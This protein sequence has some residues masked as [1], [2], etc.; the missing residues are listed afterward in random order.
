VFTGLIEQVGLVQSVAPGPVTDVWIESTFEDLKLGESIACDGCCLT[1]VKAD[2][3]RFLVQA[4]PETLRRTTLGQWHTGTQL[5]LERAM[6][7]GDRLG[8]HIVQGHVD[9]TSRVLEAR[10]DGGSRFMRFDMPRELAAYF[11]EKGSVAIDGI[12]LTVNA[13]DAR[14]FAVQLIPETQ[15]RTTL[16]KKSTG[17]QVNL[18][19]DLVGKYVARQAQLLKEGA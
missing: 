8:G 7:V 4:A 11:I 16:A 12:S 2:K 14:S 15:G 6:R 13:L 17:A 9:A 18:E 5:N 1:V 19:A 3:G 10:P